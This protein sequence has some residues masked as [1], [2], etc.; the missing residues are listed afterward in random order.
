MFRRPS[1][2]LEKSIRTDNKITRFRKDDLT[3][4]AIDRLGLRRNQGWCPLFLCPREK[5][6][7]VLQTLCNRIKI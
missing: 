5:T 6:D 3:L 1:A 4:T 7:G 2:L